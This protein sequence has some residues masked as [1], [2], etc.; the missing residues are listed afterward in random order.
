MN[1]IRNI[2]IEGD[3]N[4]SML[5]DIYFDKKI[6]SQPIVIFCHGFKGFKDWGHFDLIARAFVE[7]GFAFLKFNFS[8][9]GTTVDSPEEFKDLEAFGRNT[10]SKELNDLGNVIDFVVHDEAFIPEQVD[11]S[12]IYLIGHSKG[13]G[14]AILKANED[15][16]VKK[17]IS[18]AAVGKYGRLFE[19]ESILEELNQKGVFYILNGRTKQQM[20]LYKSFYDDFVK[21]IDRLNIP[22][23]AKK[24]SVPWL[25]VHGNNDK[26]VPYQDAL[27]LHKANAASTLLTI[28]NGDH[29]F[30]GKHPWKEKDLPEDCQK[31]VNASILFLKE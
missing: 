30:G 12:K 5:T 21:N 23:A 14:A 3:D 28:K 29:T 15:K 20:P 6:N 19:S 9:N 17:V 16:R 1:I 7:G 18:W 13:G 4:R 2:K 10:Y 8:H 31:V 27:A 11:R 25:I 26:A 24:I 22:A